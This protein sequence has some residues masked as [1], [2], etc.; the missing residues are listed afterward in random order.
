MALRRPQY[1]YGD[2]TPEKVHRGDSKGGLKFMYDGEVPQVKK[3]KH[4]GKLLQVRKRYTYP[5]LP[6][7]Q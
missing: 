6:H 4:L 5:D 7:I 1:S 2:L 3:Y